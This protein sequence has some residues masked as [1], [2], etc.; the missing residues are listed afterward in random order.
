MRSGRNANT[1]GTLSP[2]PFRLLADSPQYIM[3]FRHWWFA[4]IVV[5]LI[6]SNVSTNSD[7]LDKA[8]ISVLLA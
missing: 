2:F 8:S 6:P 4:A 7:M 1:V 3:M 5:N